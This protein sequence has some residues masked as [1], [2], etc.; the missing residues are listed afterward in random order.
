MPNVTELVM[1][2]LEF[3]PRFVPHEHTRRSPKSSKAGWRSTVATSCLH[4]PQGPDRT[5]RGPGT[6]LRSLPL[7]SSAAGTLYQESRR[8]PAV[9]QKYWRAGSSTWRPRTSAHSTAEAPARVR[10]KHQLKYSAKTTQTPRPLEYLVA[11]SHLVLEPRSHRFPPLPVIF[12]TKTQ[13][14][15]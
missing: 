13:L 5:R 11:T 12:P 2:K 15:F 14:P 8:P 3:D 10:T 9:C 4:T 6:Q 1:M 7:P